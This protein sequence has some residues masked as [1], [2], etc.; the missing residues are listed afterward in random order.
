MA[1]AKGTGPGWK[2]NVQNYVEI[3]KGLWNSIFFGQ[4]IGELIARRKYRTL[5]SKIMQCI[6]DPEFRPDIFRPFPDARKSPD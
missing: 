3:R 6:M 4:P 5:N 1:M 2:A